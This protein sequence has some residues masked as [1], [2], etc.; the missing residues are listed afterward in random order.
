MKQCVWIDFTFCP[1]DPRKYNFNSKIDIF[2]TF[3][4]LYDHCFLWFKGGRESA[5]SDV[6]GSTNWP[7]RQLNNSQ[8]AVLE[9]GSGGCGRMNMQLKDDMWSLLQFSMTHIYFKLLLYFCKCSSVGGP[10]P[11]PW[12]HPPSSLLI[13]QLVL[14][15]STSL[16]LSLTR[17]SSLGTHQCTLPNLF[18]KYFIEFVCSLTHQSPVSIPKIVRTLL[19]VSG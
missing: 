3:L 14:G 15:S 1:Y 8:T 6:G 4:Y 13:C 12:V 17:H 18:T 11:S 9:K 16:S 19:M 5:A 10:K 7:L 2:P